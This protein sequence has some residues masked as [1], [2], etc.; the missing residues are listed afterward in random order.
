MTDATIAA[1]G[2]ELSRLLHLAAKPSGSRSGPRPDAGGGAA[3]PGAAGAYRRRRPAP[4]R[5]L[6]SSGAWRRAGSSPPTRRTTELQRRAL[7]H[8]FKGLSEVAG[9]A[10]VAALVGAGWVGEADFPRHPQVKEKPASIVY[11]P[12]ASL[13]VAPDMVCL[14]L[15]AEQAI[16]F[17]DRARACASRASRSATCSPCQDA[18]ETAISVGSC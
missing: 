4:C 17:D 3:G 13:P 9:N 6:A 8:G 16:V 5:R 18:G 10:D 7:T 15:N 11:G 12:L 1:L 2:A 14:R